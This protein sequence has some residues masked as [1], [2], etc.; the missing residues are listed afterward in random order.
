M[1]VLLTEYSQIGQSVKEKF[2]IHTYIKRKYVPD[3]I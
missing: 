1:L 2:Y 3:A